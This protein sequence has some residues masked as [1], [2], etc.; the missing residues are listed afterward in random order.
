MLTG[1]PIAPAADSAFPIQNVLASLL[2]TIGFRTKR[3]WARGL[4]NEADN[5]KLHKEARF[6]GGYLRDE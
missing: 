5:S 6:P 2:S 3:P 4:L 1:K